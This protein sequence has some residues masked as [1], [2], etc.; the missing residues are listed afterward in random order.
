MNLRRDKDNG[1]NIKGY[2]AAHRSATSSTEGFENLIY[3]TWAY[4]NHNLVSETWPRHVP[5]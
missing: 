2:T 5:M 3:G 4:H 1:A